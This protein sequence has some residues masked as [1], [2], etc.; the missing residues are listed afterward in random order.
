[1]WACDADVGN[2]FVI[3]SFSISHG[4][5]LQKRQQLMRRKYLHYGARIHIALE[6]RL[7]GTPRREYDYLGNNSV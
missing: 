6:A 2:T 5:D 4:P 3:C 1:M 7:Q